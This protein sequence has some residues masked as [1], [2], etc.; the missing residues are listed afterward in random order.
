[1]NIFITQTG[2][3]EICIQWSSKHCVRRL[4]LT[5]SVISPWSIGD[6]NDFSTSILFSAQ[7]VEE[8]IHLSGLVGSRDW[9]SHLLVLKKDCLLDVPLFNNSDSES[10]KM[11]FL[12]GS[13]FCFCFCV[14]LYWLY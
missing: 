12:T 3:V 11:A 4:I 2:L 8:C 5:S 7:C 14:C 6:W 13:F 10:L 9:S 1:M